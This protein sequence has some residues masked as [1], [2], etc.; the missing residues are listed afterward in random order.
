MVNDQEETAL[1]YY[2]NN[3]KRLTP[4]AVYDIF[5]KWIGCGSS[6]CGTE[7]IIKNLEA[8]RVA[9][10][11][12][13]DARKDASGRSVKANGDVSEMNVGDERDVSGMKTAES[14]SGSDLNTSRE[15]DSSADANGSE[16]GR[17]GFVPVARPSNRS[18]EGSGEEGMA[19]TESCSLSNVN[20]ILQSAGVLSRNGC[21][22]CAEEPRIS[23]GGDGGKDLKGAMKSREEPQRETRKRRSVLQGNNAG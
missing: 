11:V 20:S 12:D 13:K 14:E 15:G 2:L 18:L 19:L 8:S 5:G 3:A 22:A 1:A 23:S 6:E 9:S 4:F 17:S 16:S 7:V 21:I 10:R